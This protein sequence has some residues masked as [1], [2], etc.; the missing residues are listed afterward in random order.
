MI[1]SCQI[2]RLKALP[3]RHGDAEFF[4]SV[5]PGGHLAAAASQP[6]WGE[7]LEE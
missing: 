7:R 2:V 6:E 4:L 5:S 3:L 1:N